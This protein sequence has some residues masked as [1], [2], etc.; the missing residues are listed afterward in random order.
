MKVV[1]Y[2][3]GTLKLGCDIALKSRL[4]VSGWNLSASLKHARKTG[5]GE[6]SIAYLDGLPVACAY[7]DNYGYVSTFCRKQQR[8]KG[9]GMLALSM[10]D[11]YKDGKLKG[12]YGING[13]SDFYKKAKVKYI[14]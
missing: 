8:R 12:S 9:F 2:K 3:E 5:E 13:S 4:Y 1:L 7:S 14:G 10:L 11:R 6:V